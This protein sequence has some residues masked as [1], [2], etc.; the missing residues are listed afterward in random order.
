MARDGAGRTDNQ[1]NNVGAVRQADVDPHTITLPVV[2]GKGI[3]F[4][5]LSTDDGLSQT[6]VSQI[7]QDDQGFMWFGSQYGLNRYDGYKF[8][9]FKHEPGNRNSLS[10]VFIYSLFKDRSGSLWIGCEEF[11][12]KFDPV[13][14]TFTHYRIDTADAQSETVPVTN[15]S[16]D[17]TGMLWLS[18]IRGLVR[19]DPSTGRIIRYRHDPNNPLSLSNDQIRTTGE[20]REGTFWVGTSEGLD[21]FDRDTEKVT[22]HVPLKDL[23]ETSFYEDRVGV[24]WIFQITGGGLAVFD[25]KTHTLTHYSFH[26]GHLSD[27]LMTGAMTMLEDRDGSLW[28]GTFGDGLVKFDRQER[29]FIRY[30]NDPATPDSLGEDNVTTLFQDREGNIWAGLHMMAPNRFSTRPPLFEKFKHEPGNPN[31]LSGTMV[32]GIYEDREGILWI[33]AINAL[34]RVDRKTGQ[35]TFYR[36]AVPGVS[37]RPTAIVEDR[38][39]FLWVGSDNHGLTR[40]DPKTGLFRTFR[41]SPTDRFSLSSDR[42]TGLFI[43]H[44]GTLWATTH[45]GLNRFD[46]A[47]SHFTVYKL[48]QQSAAQID[49]EVKEDREGAVWI[50]THSS[51]LQ[52]LDPAAGRFT[53]IY[54]HNANDPTSLSNNRVN[55]V[56]FDHSGTMWVGTQ[57]GL[58]KFDPRTAT[59]KTYYEQDGL[60]GNAVSCILEDQQ[61]S[62]WMSTNNGLSAFDPAKQTFKS[63]SA[64]DGLPGAD[65]GGWGACFKSPSGEMFFGGF[66]GGVAFH[67]DKVVDSPYV[68]PVV[69]TDFRIFGRP[70][71]VGTGSTLSKSIGYTSAMS[72][73][74][75]QNIFSLEFSALSYFNP[76]TNRYRYKLDGLDRQWHEVGSNQRL[77]TYTTLPAEVYT[78]R[79]QGATS[80][81]D[82]SEPGLELRVKILPPWWNTWWFRTLCAAAFLGVLWLLY[83]AR[84]QQLRRQERKLR[85]VIE[86]IP[87][88]AWTA[89]PDGSVDFVNRHWQEYT[90]LSTERTVGSGWQEAAHPK[91]VERNVEKWRASLATG[92]PFEDEVRYRRA[93]DGQ[94]RW[95]LSRAVPLRDGRGKILKWYGTS[96]DIED[97]KRA[98]HEREQLRTDLAH[99]NRVSILGELAASVSHELKQPIAAAMTNANTCMRWLKR[100][101]PAVDKALEAT[102][103][104]MRD[105]S[106]ATEII[107]R[108]R[109]LYKKSPPHR[110]LVDVNEIVREMLVLLR[111][112]ANR[113]SISM[114]TELAPDLPKITADRVQLQQVFMNLMLNAIEAMKDT[115]GKLTIKT[116]LGQGGQLL[117]SVSDTGVGLPD[118]NT[119]QIFN[120]FFTTKPQGSGMGLAISRSIIESHGGRLWASANNGRGATFQLTLP[121]EVTASSPSA[122]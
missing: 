34:N 89:L 118:E 51:G 21:A 9:V 53:A 50:G 90:G 71:T 117:I 92:E 72:L 23:S 111:G 64:A 19:F 68:P 86:T 20:D 12:D 122:A 103:R 32:N 96:T 79:V 37:P 39:G 110:E 62:L 84:I 4:T 106:R 5:R 115:A 121:A 78:F 11:L 44:A 98:E 99:L 104:I 66:S 41:H 61:G 63:Y 52:R 54:K 8:K 30:R 113:Y 80:R 40:F 17:H 75:D 48:D 24:F 28:F 36:T 108:L 2:D 35:Y 93:S 87:T 97:R 45:N 29:K 82:W 112:E 74:H 91:D 22:L 107:D 25:R 102:S 15:I 57:D 94:Y 105:G 83:Q 81:G 47:T 3:R 33:S 1:P 67:P 10:G 101:Q 27:A 38:L 58:G 14:D 69:L 73:S 65:L 49:I 114:R 56:L 13:T 85:D 18:T 70:V 42:I 95:F 109:S 88:F 31:S 16:Q 77:V 7:V 46:P 76:A 59:F 116:E 60:S 43:D 120:A 55:S 26:K 6:R 119:D 100:D